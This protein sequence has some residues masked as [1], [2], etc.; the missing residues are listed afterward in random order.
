MDEEYMGIDYSILRKLICLNCFNKS[1]FQCLKM[2]K[3]QKTI[4][5][6]LKNE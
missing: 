2:F 4:D 3:K 6:Q 5:E 1:H